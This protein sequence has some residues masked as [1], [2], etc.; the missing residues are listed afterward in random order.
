MTFIYFGLWNQFPKDI[1]RYT[2]FF[3]ALNYNYIVVKITRI[4]YIDIP[5][6]RK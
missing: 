1:H 5:Y 3:V 4:E 2:F 6:N